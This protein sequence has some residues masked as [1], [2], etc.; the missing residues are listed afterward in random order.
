ARTRAAAAPGRL[1]PP[2]ATPDDSV[3]N[4]HPRSAGSSGAGE[5]DPAATRS[6]DSCCSGSA[7]PGR[8]PDRQTG[9]EPGPARP[10]ASHG[11]NIA[12]SAAP[13]LD[14][15]GQPQQTAGSVLLEKKRPWPR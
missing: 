4:S 11:T 8:T 12:T 9:A 10:P 7:S 15:P 2:A 5:P 13:L 1:P 3:H 6:P 14:S